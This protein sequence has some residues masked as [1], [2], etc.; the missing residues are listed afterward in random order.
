M[1]IRGLN[2]YEEHARLLIIRQ[3]YLGKTPDDLQKEPEE[4]QKFLQYGLKAKVV[5]MKGAVLP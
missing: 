5:W 2:T 3:Q 1:D 4:K